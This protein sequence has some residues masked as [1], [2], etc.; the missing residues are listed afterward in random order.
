MDIKSVQPMSFGQ[1][2]VQKPLNGQIRKKAYCLLKEIHKLDNNAIDKYGIDLIISAQKQKKG[3][4]GRNSLCALF[5][6]RELNDVSYS[7][8]RE[9][10]YSY[11]Q[12]TIAGINNILNFIKSNYERILSLGNGYAAISQNKE[13]AQDET[14]RYS[15]SLRHK[16]VAE[17]YTYDPQD[18]CA[19]KTVVDENTNTIQK[20]VYPQKENSLF[21]Y[22]QDIN[23]HKETEKYFKI[24]Y[25][26]NGVIARELI[27]ITP[28]PYGINDYHARNYNEKGILISDE[29]HSSD[30]WYEWEW[31]DV[32]DPETG[33]IVE[34]HYNT[35]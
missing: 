23:K 6:Q 5:R 4:F 31:K 8:F 1:V 11:T 2:V 17:G 28:G 27:A 14:W 29:G 33:N 3:L 21:Y 25:H 26:P 30:Q 34:Y 7:F 15:R 18:K 22:E 35:W 19:Y 32:Y 20:L 9:S 10:A 13:L 24:F 16:V 12:N